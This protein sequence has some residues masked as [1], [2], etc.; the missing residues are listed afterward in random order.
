MPEDEPTADVVIVAGDVCEGIDSGMHLLRTLI[1]APKP[2]I[3]VAGNHEF[4]RRSLILQ[5]TNAPI[6][7]AQ[8]A[9]T[10]LDDASAVIG[11]VRFIG[12]TLWTDFCLDGADQQATRME[13]AQR[14]MLDYREIS[15][16]ANRKR[17]LKPAD[18][19]QFHQS[20]RAFLDRTLAEPFAGP[21]VVVT[22]HAPHP[23]SVAARFR[24][25][26]VTASFVSDLTDLIERHAPV[27]WVHGHTHT[28][29]DYL[30]GGTRINCNPKGY[31]KENRDFDAGLIVEI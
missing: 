21:T 2:I 13:A 14:Y 23:G 19:L 4:Y 31:G 17:K 10:F 30:V 27:L 25:D 20:S 22:H 8:Y 18:T 12:A 1:P 15:V 5:R 6:A 16:D 7:A 9:V 28:S 11:G 26:P 24:V 3:M 29:F